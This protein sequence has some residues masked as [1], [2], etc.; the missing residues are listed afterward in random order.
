MA[1]DRI[2]AWVAHP[3]GPQQNGRIC[4]LPWVSLLRVGSSR[5]CCGAAS[6]EEW[7]PTWVLGVVGRG[8][9]GGLRPVDLCEVM[10]CGT[11][12]PGPRPGQP[13]VPVAALVP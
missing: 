1:G 12:F 10:I 5:G 2:L 11:F 7:E 4:C 9:W 8:G 3:Q 13:V 6:S